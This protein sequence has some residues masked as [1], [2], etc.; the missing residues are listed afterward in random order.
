MFVVLAVVAVGLF[1]LG[2]KCGARAKAEAVQAEQGAARF[3]AKAHSEVSAKLAAVKAEVSKI[4]AEAK[5]EEQAV[6]ARLK[7]LL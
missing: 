5:T 1:F 2:C 7:A 6:V 4:E 3:Y